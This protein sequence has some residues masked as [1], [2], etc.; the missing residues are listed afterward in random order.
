MPTFDKRSL[1]LGSAA[2]GLSLALPGRAWPAVFKPHTYGLGKDGAP[3]LNLISPPAA[4]TADSIAL[5]WDKPAGLS[6]ESYE[7][8]LGPRLVATTPHTD[9]TLHGLEPGKL[10]D[11]QIR[12]RLASG[13]VLRSD[14][15]QLATKPKPITLDITR[16]GAI[17]DGKT[18]NTKAIQQ[19]IDACPQGGVVR[20]P[21]GTFLS[22]ALFLKSAMTLHLDKG[23]LL[24]GSPEASHYPIITY[25]YE[26]IER[27]CH[28][29]LIGTPEAKGQRW[30]DIAITGEGTIDGNGI[31][32]RQ[33]QN[34][35]QQGGKGRV[36]SIRDTD[37]VYLQGV[38]VR[39]SPFWCVHPVYCTGLTVN[40][41]SIHT[42]YDASGTPYPGM[43]N[44]DGLDP[45]SCRDVFIVNCHIASQ[46]DGIA[47]KSGRD[48][49]GRAVGIPT[50]NVRISHCRFTSGFGVAMG[51]EMAG[52]LR[53]VLVEDCQFE[54]TFSIASVKA[55]RPRGNVIENITYRDCTL[56]NHSTEH[57]DGR[58]FRGALYVDQFYGVAEPDL[59]TP[60]PIDEGTALIR[61]VLFQNI[62][63][64]TVG[65]HAIYLAGLPERPLEGIRLENV[66]AKGVYGLFACNIR[67]LK[68]DKVSV[69]PRFGQAMQMINVES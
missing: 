60:Q 27:P 39:Q 47:L 16:F 3:A 24:L 53:D 18:L 30:H 8:H 28:A 36:I 68:L 55:P 33:S 6:V 9:H 38:T 34:A 59:H 19:A 41:V 11:F 1:L 57:H 40:G 25:R 10:H 49:P 64:E 14:V 7:V 32:L 4:Q 26:G 48:A 31:A 35:A 54:N 17:G 23:A 15:L 58:Y 45:D 12:A 20:I 50:Q 21:A 66:T 62:T 22:G 37:G 2:T 13:S 67:G 65:G 52:G 69:E 46:D 29:S 56:V 61:N 5:L 63:L 44:G 42:K 51:S 43:V